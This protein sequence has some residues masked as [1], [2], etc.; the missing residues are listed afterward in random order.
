MTS[1]NKSSSKHF[2]LLVAGVLAI[3]L[4]L[5]LVGVNFGQPGL[6]SWT[7]NSIQLERVSKYGLEVEQ[8]YGPL[9]YWIAS[10]PCR[11]ADAFAGG[12]D[13]TGWRWIIAQR[14]FNS[15]LCS[16]CVLIVIVLTCIT[17]GRPLALRAGFICACS[18]ALI[19]WAKTES[20]N[21]QAAFWAMLFILAGTLFV[22]YV[23]RYTVLWLLAGIFAGLMIG[24][25]E[26]LL[27]G[28]VILPIIAAFYMLRQQAPR[29]NGKRLLLVQSVLFEAVAVIIYLSISLTNKS[30]FI[31]R[32]LRYTDKNTQQITA[33][34]LVYILVAGLAR[35]V[36]T[37]ISV[38]FV[39][40][41]ILSF[42]PLS[43]L[44]A[45]VGFCRNLSK[46]SL[47]NYI[48][49]IL[50]LGLCWLSTYAMFWRPVATQ[51]ALPLALMFSPFVALGIQ[52]LENWNG[53]SR[54]VRYSAVTIIYM[55]I[56]A[57]GLAVD[58]NQ[59]YNAH[60][61]LLEIAEENSE[62]HTV[63]FY[64]L[65]EYDTLALPQGWTYVDVPPGDPLIDDALKIPADADRAVTYLD[66]IESQHTLERAGWR[67]V[68]AIE[69][70][71]IGSFAYPGYNTSFRLFERIC[72]Q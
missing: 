48:P 19:F 40:L 36:V 29:P 3:S 28:L 62:P 25:K 39:S 5:N 37:F 70:P 11:I 32:L 69:N 38:V 55:L 9:C 41:Q 15:L 21:P 66:D 49:L 44:L 17:H 51:D 7:S 24:T 46:S 72:G 71:L 22:K 47:L 43:I 23:F 54:F 10:V 14:V 59:I 53:I 52:G 31:T 45:A 6:Q 27:G 64:S 35:L 8:H 63:L 1:L 60:Y 12:E 33:G 68:Q 18:P 16:A 26:T 2:L 61:G 13:P 30:L 67:S 50:A 58:L 20:V 65:R 57:F 56:F 42:F 34:S 4:T